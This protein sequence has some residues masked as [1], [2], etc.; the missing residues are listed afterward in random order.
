VLGKNIMVA[1]GYGEGH[2]STHGRQE[3]LRERK[4]KRAQEKI[5][6]QEHITNNSLPP[7]RLCLPKIPLFP[8]ITLPSEDQ[9]L[10]N[11]SSQR[12]L[13]IQTITFGPWLPKF[14]KHF[15]MQN[16]FCLSPSITKS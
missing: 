14:H 16:V 15:I 1:E 12:I 8:K 9:A 7:T 3:A 4:T 6:S 11:E 10:N 5:W 13:H 2:G